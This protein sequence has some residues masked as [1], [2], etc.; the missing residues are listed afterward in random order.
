M[1]E[2]SQ[3]M[4]LHYAFP[5][6]QTILPPFTPIMKRLNPNIGAA[7]SLQSRMAAKIDALLENPGLLD[8][9]EH[10][11]VYHHLMTPQLGEKM[12]SRK[13]LIDEVCIRDPFTPSLQC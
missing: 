13:S 8:S 4:W 1:D 5:I 10:E 7:L 3:L 6:L 9:V 2:L 12:P 11:I